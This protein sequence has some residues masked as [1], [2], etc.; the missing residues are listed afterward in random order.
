MLPKITHPAYDF[1]IPI[2]KK[3]VKLRPMLIKEEKL[4]LMARESDTPSDSINAIKQVVNNCII[5][6]KIDIDALINFELEYLFLKIR[7]ISVSN[8]VKLAYQD[9]EDEKTYDFEIDLNEIGFK[10]SEKI[11]NRVEL[12]EDVS[13]TLKYPSISAYSQIKEDMTEDEI[14]THVL[15][16]SIDGIY[17]GDKIH[18][19]SL[20]SSEEI[21]EFID[22]I[23]F[24]KYEEIQKYLETEPR[25][26]HKIQYKNSNG[27]DREI[28]LS[29]LNDFFIL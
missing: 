17:E 20:A 9:S 15:K 23:P 16:S 29:S 25:I 10:E 3:K 19:I 11:D 5:Q 14:F 28:V 27:T 18:D 24:N 8:I 22:S 26:E 2:T 21:T 6:P 13:I 12:S 7:S 4:L 1:T